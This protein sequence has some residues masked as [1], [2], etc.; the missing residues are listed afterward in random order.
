MAI[1][2]KEFSIFLRYFLPA[3]CLFAVA[4][5]VAGLGDRQEIAANKLYRLTE[6]EKDGQGQRYYLVAQCANAYKVLYSV[7]D[8]TVQFG[9]ENSL[10]NGALAFHA[11][12]IG[13]PSDRHMKYIGML[14]SFVGG[15]TVYSYAKFLKASSGKKNFWT[16][17]TLKKNIYVIIGAITGYALGNHLGKTYDTDCDSELWHDIV[18][19]VEMWRNF[20]KTRLAGSIKEIQAREGAKFT[21]IAGRN[22]YPM[23]EDPIV[24]CNPTFNDRVN[25]FIKIVCQLDFDPTSE[26]FALLDGLKEKHERLQNSTTYNELVRLAP[27]RLMATRNQKAS[28]DYQALLEKA[29]YSKEIWDDLCRQLNESIGE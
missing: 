20:E 15:P 4:G 6:V 10:L 28:K 29:G 27:Y 7:D 13:K 25:G 19:N 17:N 14:G 16:V 26:Q 24:M 2:F 21:D 3:F 5:F 12:S 11:S 18:S 23:M 9:D 22:V 1:K 8:N